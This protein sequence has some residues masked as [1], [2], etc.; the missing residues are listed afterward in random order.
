MDIQ[1]KN[2]IDQM[3]QKAMSDMAFTVPLHIHNGIDAPKI[4]A[5]NLNIIPEIGIPFRNNNEVYSIYSTTDPSRFVL[6]PNNELFS[7]DMAQLFIGG[8]SPYPENPFNR[9][10]IN[11]STTDF[12]GD[13][14]TVTANYVDGVNPDS[15]TYINIGLNF[16]TSCFDGV[17]GF[18]STFTLTSELA[19]FTASDAF[20]ILLPDATLPSPVEGMIAYDGTNFRGVDSSG[21]WKTFTLT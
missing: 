10:Y 14:I 9:I 1:I 21:T 7:T 20:A 12:L 19:Q 16:T 17:T 4:L 2:Y 5:T 11:T 6:T 3:I 8:M 18:I 13:G 15:I